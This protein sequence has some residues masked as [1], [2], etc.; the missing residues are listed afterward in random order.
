MSDIKTWKERVADLHGAYAGHSPMQH[1][2]DYV[3]AEISELRA[4]VIELETSVDHW[5]AAR[6]NAL[7]AGDILLGELTA[8]RSEMAALEG[9]QGEPVAWMTEDG[10]VCTHETKNNGMH[11]RTSES[12]SIPLYLAA[13]ARE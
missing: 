10:R 13:G 9:Q 12:Y 5:K 2:S 1:Y 3:Q 8:C 6:N 4:R 11:K 7:A